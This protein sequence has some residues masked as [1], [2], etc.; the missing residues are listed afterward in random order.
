MAS[1]CTGGNF[2]QN[3]L[4]ELEYAIL[5]IV[6][7]QSASYSI[8]SRSFSYHNLNDLINM[9]DKIKAQACGSIY[10]NNATFRDC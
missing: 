10:I 3:L 9:R 1:D 5:A 8:G 4:C 7:G 2:N 6:S